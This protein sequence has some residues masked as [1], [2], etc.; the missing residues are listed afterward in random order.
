MWNPARG[1]Y[2]QGPVDPVALGEPWASEA[3]DPARAE[4]GLYQCTRPP[5]YPPADAVGYAWIG[6]LEPVIDPEVLALQAIEQMG[7]SPVRAATAPPSPSAEFPDS[8]G[9]VGR[10]VFL[11]ADTPDDQTWGP[12]SRTAAAG[13]VS[14]TA[15]ARV[16]HAEWDMG[17]GTV[18]RCDTPGT[19]WRWGDIYTDCGHTYTQTSS[20][21]AGQVYPIAATTFWEVTWN[22]G[23]AS[24]VI[25]FSLTADTTL[26]VG[27]LQALRVG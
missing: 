17:D 14:V 7:L 21:Q 9:L 5:P 1:C 10:E 4:Q 16:S 12:I 13:S 2:I 11:W 15:Q 19:A 3:A 8:M 26:P 23:G 20:E 27:E 24:G 18:V 6:A 25:D 22:G